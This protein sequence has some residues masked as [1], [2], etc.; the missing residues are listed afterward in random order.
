MK[1]VM[2]VL[3]VLLASIT[4]VMVAST[5][6]LVQEV[7]AKDR[8]PAKDSKM[9]RDAQTKLDGG[10]AF[11][12]QKNGNYIDPETGDPIAPIVTPP[13]EPL[14]PPPSQGCFNDPKNC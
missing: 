2:V 1:F 8:N 10:S 13:P 9:Q 3:V 4:S 11:K 12:Q 7:K 14:P 6:D 5:I